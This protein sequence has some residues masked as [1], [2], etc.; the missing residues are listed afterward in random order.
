MSASRALVTAPPGAPR[1]RAR[2]GA[3]RVGKCSTGER[4]VLY[5]RARPPVPGCPMSGTPC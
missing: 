5:R 3:A 2:P 1:R 4:R